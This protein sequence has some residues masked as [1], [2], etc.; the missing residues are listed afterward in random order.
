[1]GENEETSQPC[2]SWRKPESN[3]LVQV[4]VKLAPLLPVVLNLLNNVYDSEYDSGDDYE[5]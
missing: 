5:L 2:F 1:M 3:I 4:F